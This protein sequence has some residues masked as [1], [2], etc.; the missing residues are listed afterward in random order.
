MKPKMKR[1]KLNREKERENLRRQSLSSV[2]SSDVILLELANNS[3]FFFFFPFNGGLRPAFR[4]ITLTYYD[5][6]S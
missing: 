6:E 5:K 1:Q 4:F 2:I 3:I